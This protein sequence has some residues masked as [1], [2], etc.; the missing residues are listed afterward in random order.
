MVSRLTLLAA[1]LGCAGCGFTHGAANGGG[2]GPTDGR[3]QLDAPGD[4]GGS[5]VTALTCVTLPALGV[6]L[7]PS[8]TPASSLEITADESLKT[9]DGTS[10]PSDPQLA[11]A[12]T[13][14][15]T[16]TAVCVL[17]AQTITID[18]GAT[19]SGH[20]G[21]ALVLF[22]TTSIDVEGTIDV[23]SHISGGPQRVGPGPNNTC[24][25]GTA[26]AGGAGGQGGSFG[27][28]GGDGGDDANGTAGGKAGAA[29]VP[30]SVT[31][32]RGCDGHD[33]AG[34][35]GTHGS[36]GG[37]VLLSTPQL[38]V[39]IAG[40]INASGSAAAGPGS[41]NKGGGGGGSGGLI[42]LDA[43]TITINGAGQIFANGAGGSSG[44]SNGAGVPG[45]DPP[46]ATMVASG[47]HVLS[48]AGDGGD[49]A[50]GPM[51][52]T[53]GDAGMSG[54]GGGGGGGGLGYVMVHSGTNLS[55]NTNVSPAP[56]AL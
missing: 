47:G 41:G 54:D 37:V 23:A 53:T 34:A 19:L 38:T 28:V 12:T 45:N 6:D 29:I 15:G 42:V 33:G 21:K 14:N 9:D 43:S 3:G 7:C 50:Y 27:S 24:N 26:P 13:P 44:S 55:G 10:M 30:A 4:T 17:Y 8:G 31:L 16:P 36:G 35:G 2:G 51:P 49:G 25:A 56:T 1:A 46:S 18:A 20:G 52:A 39:G 48:N 5:D 22:A 40:V 11:C 32:T